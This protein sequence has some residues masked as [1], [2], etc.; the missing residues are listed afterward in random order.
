MAVYPPT[1][2]PSFPILPSCPQR[3]HFDFESP[4]L[5][6]SSS[7]RTTTTSKTWIYRKLLNAENLQTTKTIRTEKKK[8]NVTR[9]RMRNR[10]AFP[11]SK[12]ESAYTYIEIHI[13]KHINN[14]PLAYLYMYTQHTHT[15]RHREHIHPHKSR[16]VPKFESG[17][18]WAK[19]EIQLF[20]LTSEA[21]KLLSS[22]MGSKSPLFPSSLN[23]RSNAKTRTEL[24]LK[25]NKNNNK[26]NKTETNKIFY[27]FF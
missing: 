22:S 12:S 18:N 10:S 27:V 17:L 4:S 15:H 20:S 3:V 13:H 23:S 11:F 1:F 5:F 2:V 21:K 19:P 7:K 6:A 24:I 16:P 26:Q 25:T 9:I 8:L 14:I